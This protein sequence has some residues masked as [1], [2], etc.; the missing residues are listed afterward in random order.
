V[1]F[2]LPAGRAA[3]TPT[4]K[5]LAAFS[6]DTFVLWFSDRRWVFRATECNTKSAFPCAFTTDSPKIENTVSRCVYAGVAH[7]YVAVAHCLLWICKPSVVGS[8]PTTG[9]S[10]R[11]AA[12]NR[13]PAD[14]PHLA[15]ARAAPTLRSAGVRRPVAA[16]G[17]KEVEQ[18][19][20][21]S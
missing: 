11:A 4:F 13:T 3:P 2:R 7:V 16:G 18:R 10:F 8:S 12:N 6:R 20:E 9:S 19:A 21:F 1:V 17:E 5:S 15:L 14:T